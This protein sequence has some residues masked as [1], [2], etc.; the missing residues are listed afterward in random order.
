MRTRLP[1]LAAT[2][3]SA[4][5]L[6]LAPPP[7]RACGRIGT[8]YCFGVDA[9]FGFEGDLDTDADVPP[10]LAWLWDGS[11]HDDLDPTVGFAVWGDAAVHTYINLGGEFRALWMITDDMDD[12]D[13][14]RS[15]LAEI[16]A[17]VRVG[18][19]VVEGLTLYGRAPL[20]LTILVPTEDL[21]PD[22]AE[23]TVAP[24]LNFG[25][26]AG[27]AYDFTERLGVRLELGYVHHFAW[28][29]IQSMVDSTSIDISY[30]A[31]QFALHVGFTF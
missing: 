15:F 27:A 14:D 5:V 16:N 7:A 23:L 30:A 20:G 1:A 11:T 3:L 24:G 12:A 21:N 6:V 25:L 28:G 8:G 29:E 19:E 2:A 31:P 22:N 10:A 9:Q 4:A 17:H 13:Y 18:A 26:L